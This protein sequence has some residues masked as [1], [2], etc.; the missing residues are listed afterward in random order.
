L[1]ARKDA[2]P[3][4]VVL[5]P[6]AQSARRLRETLAAEAGAVLAPRMLTPGSLLNPE[7][8][9]VAP[10][11]AEQT[12]WLD[13]LENIRDWSACEALFPTP[14][15]QTTDWAN[16][17]A[18]ELTTLRRHLQENGL[19]LADAARRLAESIEA[20]RWAVLSRLEEQVEQRL[21]SWGWRSRS[22]V[23]KSG[24]PLP[25]GA[26][27]FVLAGVPDLPPLVARALSSATVPVFSLI[28]AP[29]EE[30][31]NFTDLGQP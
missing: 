1:L 10:D 3:G 17:L 27:T 8:P 22:R 29:E 19:M 6:T 2:L 30:A 21:G 28:G 7:D 23:L 20:D 12:A 31:G 9:D 14:P 26:T 16:G 25:S 15:E 18:T 11:W 5:T 4:M 24:I 13:T